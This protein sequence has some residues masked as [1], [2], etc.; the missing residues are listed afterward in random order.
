MIAVLLALH[1]SVDW[2]TGAPTMDR[3]GWLSASVGAGA[4]VYF[5]SLIV[6]GMRPAQFRV[7]RH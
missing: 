4:G 1:R 2:W 6:L 5:V 7:S 3:V